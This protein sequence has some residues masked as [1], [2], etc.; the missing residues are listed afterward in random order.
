MGIVFDRIIINVPDLA[1]A[2]IQYEQL[3]GVASVPRVTSRGAAAAWLG[4]PNDFPISWVFAW[5]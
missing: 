5:H 4:L 3:L 2:I 1:A